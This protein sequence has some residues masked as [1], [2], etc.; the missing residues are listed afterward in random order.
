MAEVKLSDMKPNSHKSKDTPP[1]VTPVVKAD[2]VVATK[3]TLGQ[4]FVDTFVRED[5]NDVKSW[6]ITDVIVPGV[7][8]TVLDMLS[9]LFFGGSNGYRRGGY[10]GYSRENVSY[11]SYNTYY[12]S[13]YNGQTNYGPRQP[14]PHEPSITDKIDYRNIILAT[15]EGAED[16]VNQMRYRISEFGQVSIAEMLDTMSITGNYTD[17]NWG[18]RNV[19]DIGLRRVANGWLIDVP[20]AEWIES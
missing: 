12:K 16:V 3:K 8:N 19:N 14:H 20:D 5:L 17:N 15:R 13:Q 18:W 10:R 9:M 6:I 7:K 11:N 1:K 4:K 2:Q